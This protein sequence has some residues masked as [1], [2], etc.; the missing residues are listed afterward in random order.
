MPRNSRSRA[1]P[2]NNKSLRHRGEGDSAVP[3]WLEVSR[4]NG[5]PPTPPSNGGH[6]SPTTYRIRFRRC[7]S[8]ASS[9]FGATNAPLALPQCAICRA[10][11]WSFPTRWEDGLLFLFTALYKYYVVLI[12]PE[13]QVMSR[14]GAQ[15]RGIQFSVEFHDHPLLSLSL[16]S[17]LS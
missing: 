8:Q 12:L 9:A 2:I 7:S 14:A 3:P 13:I 10:S 5:N 11:T 6:P 1:R 15:E 17:P 16:P 4:N